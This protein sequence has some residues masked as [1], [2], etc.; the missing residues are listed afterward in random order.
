MNFPVIWLSKLQGCISLPTTEVE[1]IVLLQSMREL[2]PFAGL[3]E[4]LND[5]LNKDKLK[6][7]VKYKLFEDNN[8]ALELAK[9]PR[10]R[11]RTK[12]IAL[13][14]NY[15]RNF[16]KEDRVQILPIDT[17]EQIAD[18]FTKG[19]CNVTLFKYLR[20]KLLDWI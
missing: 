15:F 3:V 5:I 20:P 14:Y 1:Y 18:I 2:I 11:P 12:H 10:Y 8:G 13:K 6:P 17:K 7:V 16:V 4:E 9:S 19:I